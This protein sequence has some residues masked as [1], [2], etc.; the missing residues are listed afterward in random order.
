MLT[1]SGYARKR[2]RFQLAREESFGLGFHKVAPLTLSRSFLLAYVLLILPT[3]DNIKY[4][5][6]YINNKI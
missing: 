6:Y 1:A 2:K 3:L 4:K 5:N